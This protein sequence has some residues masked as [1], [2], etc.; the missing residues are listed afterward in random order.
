MAVPIPFDEG[1]VVALLRPAEFHH[2]AT[3]RLPETFGRVE[4]ILRFGNFGVEDID[5]RLEGL[6]ALNSRIRQIPVDMF[7]VRRA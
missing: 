3:L 5:P 4:S 1:S 2:E 6:D 7:S